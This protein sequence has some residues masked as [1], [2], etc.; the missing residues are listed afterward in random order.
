MVFRINKDNFC[1]VRESKIFRKLTDDIFKEFKSMWRKSKLRMIELV[2]TEL[3]TFLLVGFFSRGQAAI[4]PTWIPLKPAQDKIPQ[5]NIT[6]SDL[7]QV[8]FEIKIPGI[9]SEEISTSGGTYS[10]LSVSSA[11]VTSV[12][13]RPSLPV[14]SRMVQIPFGAEVSLMVESYESTEKS[15]TKM[16]LT[17]PIVPVQPSLPKITGAERQIPFTLDQDYYQQNVFLPEKPA[18]LGEIGIIRGHR[19]VT[20]LIYPISYNPRSGRVKIYS[21]IKLKLNLSNSDLSSTQNQLHRYTSPP[22]EELCSKLLV[23]YR[24]YA[25]MAKTTRSSPWGYLIITPEEFYPALA[26]FIEWKTKKGFQVTVAQVPEIGSTPEEIKAYI[27]NAY[28]N[29]TVPPTYLLLVGDAEYLPTWTGTYSLTATDLDYVQMNED[30]FADIFRGRLPAKSLTEAEAMVDKILYYENPA[31][32]DLDW[33]QK[34]CFVAASDLN[35]LAAKTHDY[36]MM[37]YCKPRGMVCDSVWQSLRGIAGMITGSVDE[38]RA[39]LCYSGH[40]SESGWSSI[41]FNQTDVRNLTNPGKY[42]FVLSHACLTGRFNASESYGETWAKTTGVAGIAFWGASN[43]TYWDEDDILEKRMFQA[44]FAET[45]FSIGSMTDK[46]LEYLYQYYGGEGLS[47]YYLDAYNVMGDPSVDLWTKASGS[48]NVTF[49]PTIGPGTS[50]I[51]FTVM[52]ADSTPIGRALVCLYKR[53]EVFQTGLTDLLGQLTLYPSPRFPGTMNL[54]V[55]AHNY[56]PLVDSILVLSGKGDVTGDGQI[57]L[58]D[59]VFIINYLYKNGLPPDPLTRGD[60][61]C[62]D[63]ID[64]GDLVYLTNYLYKGGPLP[65]Y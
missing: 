19:F 14:I 37:N 47:R 41:P 45:C 11:G 13:S 30:D 63:K 36:V 31:T 52:S 48:M 56:L 4:S 64:L 53:D 1:P 29:W 57:N 20:V 15:L 40:G 17:R 34:A 12:I 65:C 24:S 26:N 58:G 21:D 10:S 46:A 9:W 7:S 33:M 16:K 59:L 8:S 60:V 3:I 32:S 51:T 43:Y 61:N 27:Q 44:A 18:K 49:T 35:N 55:S 25:S 54:T 6:R 38:G 39:I 22:F 42:P 62:D 50:E 5:L 23:N 28:Q 2:G